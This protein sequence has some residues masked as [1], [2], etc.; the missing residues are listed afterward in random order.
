VEEVVQDDD[1]MP[2]RHPLTTFLCNEHFAEIMGPAGRQ[3]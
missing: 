1:P 2:G 3:T